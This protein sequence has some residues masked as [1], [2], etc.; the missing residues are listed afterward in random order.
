MFKYQVHALAMRKLGL[1][2]PLGCL[3]L[4][5]LLGCVIAGAIYFA[6]IFHAIEQRSHSPHVHTRSTH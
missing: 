1:G 4:V 6:V 3:V 5:V 2:K